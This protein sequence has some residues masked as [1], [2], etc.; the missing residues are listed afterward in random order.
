MDFNRNSGFWDFIKR[1]FF[2]LTVVLHIGWGEGFAQCNT[3][4]PQIDISFNTDQD[5]APVTVTQFNI[6]YYFNVAQNPANIQIRYDWN[7]PANTSTTIN[8]GNGLIASAGN[9]SFSANATFTYFDNNGQCNIR[10]TASIIINGVLCP[11]SSQTQLAFFWGTDEQANG[12]LSMTPTNWEVC[13][14]NPVVNA[15][16]FD[17][18][19]FNCNI[20]VEPDNPNR[21]A[22]HVQ[23]IYG[24]NHNPAATIRNLTLNDGAVQGLTNAVG[25]RVNTIT[26]GTAGLQIAG[27]Y[28]GPIDAIPF[29]ADGPVSFTFPMS[30]PAN[31][32][33]AVGNRFEITLANWNICN[34]WNGNVAAPNYE[35]AIFTTGYI[36]IVE[37]PNP[38]FITRNSSGTQTKNFCI[39]ETIFFIN[40][41]PNVNAYNYTWEFYDDAAGTVLLGTRNQRNPTF[42]FPTGG[43]KLIRVRATNPTAQG[44][45]VEEF[46]DVV[47][48]TP[49]LVAAIGVTDLNGVPITT[50]F[51]QNATA[52]FNSFEVRFSD[53]SVGTVTP[54]TQWRWEFTNE[55]NAVVRREPATGYSNAQ[56]GPFDLSFSNVGVY[57]A[58]LFVRD[59]VTNCQ[60]SAEVMVRVLANPVANF[61][62][63]RVCEGNA[64]AF[65]D[66]STINSVNGHQINARQWDM[67][68][69][70]V[71]FNPDPSLNNRQN[72]TYTFPA[73]DTYEVALR[74]ATN[75]GGCSAITVHT[76]TVDPLPGA[77]FSVDVNSGCS[78]LP[79]T[80]TNNAV[81]GQPDVIDRFIWEVNSGSIFQVDS[82]QRPTDAD[83]GALYIRN[84]ENFAVVNKD[85]QVR[86]RV[87]TQNGCERVSSPQTITVFPGPRSG[88]ISLN[89]SPFNDNC[90]PQTVNFSVDDQTRALNPSDYRWRV[91]DNSGVLVEQ[92][93]GNNPSFSFRFEN[94]SQAIRDYEVT[95]RTTL[96]TLCNRDSSKIVRI[97]PV[98]QANFVTDTLLF[99]CDEMN[100]RYEAQQKGLPEYNWLISVNDEPL[101]SQ[102]TSSDV[103][104]YNF[105]RV[106]A[107]QNV[108]VRLQ[109]RNFANCESDIAMGAVIVPVNDNLTAS[110]V[111]SPVNQT[112]PDATVT[113]TNNSNIGPWQYHWDFGDGTTSTAVNP[114]SHTYPTYGNYTIA[115]TVRSNTCERTQFIPVV[116][117]PI[118]PQLDFSFTES[119]CAPLTVHFTNHSL[120]AD[121]STYRWEFGTNQGTSQAINPTYTYNE[122]GLYSV[123]LYASNIIGEV[124]SITKGVIEVFETPIAQFTIKPNRVFIPGG[125]VFT[126]NRSL[127]AGSYEWDFGDGQTSN[128]FEPIISYTSSGIYSISLK[129][130]N[131]DGC[132]DVAVL[133]SIVQVEDG[134]HILLPNAFTPGKDG[135]GSGD[136][137]NDVFLP[138]TRGVTEFQM[139]IFNRWGELLF[140]SRS[141]TDGWD[142]YYQGKLCQQDVY[143]YKITAKYE[144]GDVISRSGD[145]HLMR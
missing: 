18:S 11:S 31:A 7:D 70:G 125:K 131:S 82:I 33:N 78:V 120:Y 13:Y 115:L 49:S 42:S 24:T 35:D 113:L 142:G 12:N 47:N 89:Y 85:Y 62:F 112:L 19:D 4:R 102:V 77:A 126:N 26:R 30:A 136:G 73:P 134:S 145:I 48:I 53:S 59:N 28:F 91:R 128:L 110:F 74:V 64:T 107:L 45:C 133:E 101:F 67:N 81:V 32:A 98:P 135:P 108:S 46:T 23:F 58:R 116:I 96:P 8:L 130:T 137:I 43:T 60:S 65:N 122:P 132:E 103:F 144:N 21:F 3:L 119:G 39:D 57:R 138:L 141:V 17:T 34:P 80:L 29:P 14:D 124:V 2:G 5:C 84:F 9:T 54:N 25:N 93:T 20:G 106:A 6:T 123:T 1:I 143:V 97:N 38:S 100:F 66:A 44:S 88:F 121:A 10:P 118:L 76:V 71:T 27:A 52:P 55:N 129:A 83:F 37:A 94:N 140:E 105:N 92:S 69:D 95:L 15:V 86:L 51:C 63:N 68:Y 139:L 36:V 87:I 114:G 41:T 90:S 127:G 72:F 117:N 75:M 22:R 61:T 79:V 16:F 40:Q 99:N 50:T 56:L 111:A 109:T 104:T